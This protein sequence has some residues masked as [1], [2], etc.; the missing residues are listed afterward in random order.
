VYI[1]P[2]GCRVHGF[3]KEGNVVEDDLSV[4][5]ELS[6][7]KSGPM[8][9]TKNHRPAVSPEETEEQKQEE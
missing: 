6:M 3:D 1:L 5:V 7:Y 9:M 4:D 2:N 8:L